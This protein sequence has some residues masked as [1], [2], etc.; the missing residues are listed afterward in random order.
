MWPRKVDSVGSS[1]SLGMG[2]SGSSGA[3]HGEHRDVAEL[4]DSEAMVFQ[5][6]GT[7]V[8]CKPWLERDNSINKQ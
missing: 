4:Q 7:W 6:F 2:C 5:P 1:S 3:E 8:S